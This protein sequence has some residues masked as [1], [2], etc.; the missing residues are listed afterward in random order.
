MSN[1][2]TSYI[3]PNPNKGQE[4]VK[5]NTFGK[6]TVNN[7]TLWARLLKDSGNKPFLPDYDEA[8]E[9]WNVLLDDIIN[10]LSKHN[11]VGLTKPL[12]NQYKEKLIWEVRKA[13]E[14]EFI[15]IYFAKTKQRED[16]R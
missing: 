3:I 2:L 1:A 5:L 15:K 13:Y 14:L 12:F 6:F 7:D 10:E 9:Y 11:V 8:R 16:F 4:V